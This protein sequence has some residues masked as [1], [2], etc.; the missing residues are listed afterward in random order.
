MRFPQN[1]IIFEE[2]TAPAY[3]M[4]VFTVTN[5][6]LI[7]IFILLT[8]NAH[9][10]TNKTDSSANVAGINAAVNFYHDYLYPEPALYNGS[11]YAYFEYYPFEINEGHPYFLSKYFNQGSLYYNG[12]LY[13][14]ISLLFDLIQDLVL[15]HDPS[16]KYIIKLYTPQID[17][18][19]ISG[20]TFIHLR[21]DSCS[22]VVMKDGFYQVL[23][24]GNTGLYKEITKVLKES[25]TSVTGIDRRVDE[26]DYYFIQKGGRY[27]SIKNRKALLLVLNDKKK[28]VQQ[29]IKKNRLNWKR[30]KENTLI[31]TITF[32][33]ALNK[34]NDAATDH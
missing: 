2:H 3:M 8:N 4:K 20:N 5:F 17:W 7:N 22:N 31:Q 18:F 26:T 27:Y 21:A 9:C 15:I 10:Q 33:D 13:K 16:T 14:N 28:E 6:L 19:T 25:L 11:E 32:Y 29:F 24:K 30:D 1:S 12:I 34:S 23:C